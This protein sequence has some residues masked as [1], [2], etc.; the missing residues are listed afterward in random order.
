METKYHEYNLYD[1]DLL[2][3]NIII[4][5][6]KKMHLPLFLIL[7]FQNCSNNEADEFERS[8]RE[9]HSTCYQ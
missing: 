2:I 5:K 3:K 4:V 8:I 1:N 6:L 9:I 7:S